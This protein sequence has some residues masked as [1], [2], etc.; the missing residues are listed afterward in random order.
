M[1]EEVDNIFPAREAGVRIVRLKMKAADSVDEDKVAMVVGRGAQFDWV[2]VRGVT[3]DVEG[4]PHVRTDEGSY[5][6][7]ASILDKSD[8]N[9]YGADNIFMV[10]ATATRRGVDV[11]PPIWGKGGDPFEAQLRQ[12]VAVALPV[13]KEMCSCP[14]GER[15]LA[16]PPEGAVGRRN[17]AQ[18]RVDAADAH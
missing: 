4:I 10:P 12:E 1:V 11:H 6:Y 8:G 7:V 5:D 15:I 17:D 14:G 3:T 13:D 18:G 16:R 2:A 9:E